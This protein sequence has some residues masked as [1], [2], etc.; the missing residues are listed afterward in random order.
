[1]VQ[2]AAIGVGYGWNGRDA[3]RQA[4]QQSLD[5]LGSGKAA[6]ALVCVAQEFDPAEALVGITSLLPNTPI[7]GASSPNTFT[8]D[9]EHSRSVVIGLIRGTA[10]KAY[11][12]W[13]PEFTKDSLKCARQLVYAL[14][15][16]SPLQGLLLSGDGI[17]GDYETLCSNLMST[18]IPVAGYLA[19]GD[20]NI[21]RTVVIGGNQTGSGA[22]S[23][24][25][26]GGTF[27]LGIGVGHGFTDTGIF[28]RITK[29]KDVWVQSINELPAAEVYGQVFGYTGH[30]WALP[31]LAEMVRLY[32]LG[33]ETPQCTSEL[34]LRAPLRVEADGSL[35]MNFPVSEGA[36]AHFMIGDLD[37]CLK[38]VESAARQ[39]LA[40]IYNSR[41]LLALAMVDLGWEY[42]FETRPGQISQIL[43][44]VFGDIPVVG[45]YSLGQITSLPQ[46]EKIQV[47]NQNVVIAVLGEAAS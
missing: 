43:K 3:A 22:L 24:I 42:L 9:G 34:L 30:D 32:P 19:A 26:L 15:N 28:F 41:P 40:A 12:Y 25:L 38:A 37:A 18:T 45:T 27:R 20:Y 31:P 2:G 36:V 5:R 46:M 6:L 23:G 13:N 10:L 29:A 47:H 35:R 16:H 21:G 33:I 8:S 44:N 17:N 11:S 4:T 7:W 1:M 14:I 39:A